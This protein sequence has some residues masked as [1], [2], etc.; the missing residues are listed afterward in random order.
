MNSNTYLNKYTTTYSNKHGLVQTPI[1]DAYQYHT[2][3]Q[4]IKE[5]QVPVFSLSCIFCSSCESVSL[6]QEGSF[7]QCS[8]CK[9]QFKAQIKSNIVQREK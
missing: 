2:H 8:N 9:K 3:S 4:F 7:R 6:N 5:M 1:Q